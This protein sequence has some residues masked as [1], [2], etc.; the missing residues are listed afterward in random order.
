MR[1]HSSLS[2]RLLNHPAARYGLAL[3]AAAFAF[4]AQWALRDVLHGYNPYLTLI[5]AIGFSAWYCG[6]LPS[7]LTVIVSTVAAR[8]WFI[9][10][11]HSFEITSFEQAIGLITFLLVSGLFILM[12]E[13]RRRDNEIL[14]RAHADLENRV[15]QRT[16]ELNAANRSLRELSARL[17]QLQDDER[18]RIARELHDSVGQMLVALGMN[19]STVKADLERLSKAISAVTDSASLV[20]DL[21]TEIRT[22][23]HLLHPPLLDEAG[24]ASALRWYVDGFAE[25][26]KIKVDLDIAADFGR[27]SRELETAI[28]RVVQECLTNIHRHSDSPSAKIRLTCS[29]NDIRV[30][31]KDRGIGIAPAKKMAMETTGIPGVGVRGMH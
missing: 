4:L 2:A 22:I 8:Y 6:L 14:Q 12:G 15:Q 9:R 7:I 18:R 23:S 28:F 25:R 26:S 5:A 31:V 10:P 17:M 24:L 27:F 13:A 11:L 21:N 3:L 1:T 19:L 29:A 30:E 20:D 16:A